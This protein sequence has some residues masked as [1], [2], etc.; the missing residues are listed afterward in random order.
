[1]RVAHA[2]GAV[3]RTGV[4]RNPALAG[5]V[6][7]GRVGVRSA[8]VALVEMDKLRP[9]LREEAVGAVWSGFVQVATDHGPAQ[10][11]GLR[12]ALIAAH[13]QEGEFQRRADKVKCGVSLSQ[14]FDDDGMA[15]Y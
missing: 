2:T 12:D 9:R 13:G 8:A 3:P 15:E 14:P 1:M 4:V 7:G 10:I 5:A 6:F 11:R